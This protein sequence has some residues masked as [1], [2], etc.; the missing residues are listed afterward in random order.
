METLNLATSFLGGVGGGTGLIYIIFKQVVNRI[1][2]LEGHCR[3][4]IIT[5][6]SCM[7]QREY[8]SFKITVL[9]EKLNKIHEESKEQYKTLTT[10]LDS[11]HTLIL[12]KLT[13]EDR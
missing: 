2:K 8:T 12:T 4:G 13:K 7:Q 11:L 3:D 6:E 10:K 1:E 9:E 5:K